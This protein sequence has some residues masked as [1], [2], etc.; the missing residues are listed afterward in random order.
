MEIVRWTVEEQ[1]H[2]LNEVKCDLVA[3][4]QRIARYLA[5]VH[6]QRPVEP[7]RVEESVVMR[8]R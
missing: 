8:G 6:D 5:N 4:E 2:V 1:S 7:T 3:I